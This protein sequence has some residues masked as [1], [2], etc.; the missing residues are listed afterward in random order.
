MNDKRLIIRLNIRT[1]GPA[2]LALLHF[3]ATDDD[4]KIIVISINLIF[5]SMTIGPLSVIQCRTTPT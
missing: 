5:I 4:R 3:G 2:M 1:I